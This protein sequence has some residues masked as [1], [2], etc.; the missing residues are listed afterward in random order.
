MGENLVPFSPLSLLH[1]DDDN[2]VG[3][4]WRWKSSRVVQQRFPTAM[5][6]G[7]GAQTKKGWK[8]LLRATVLY[9]LGMH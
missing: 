4:R 2:A 6:R 1:A 5:V 7:S 8:T 9:I 3:G